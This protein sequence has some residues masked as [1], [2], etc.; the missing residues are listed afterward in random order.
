[1]GL[2]SV[3]VAQQDVEK[4][5]QDGVVVLNNVVSQQTLDDLAQALDDNMKSPG[6][7]ANE[8]ADGS[9]QGRFFDDYVNWARFAA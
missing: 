9:Q 1:M 5:Q 8:Y 3:L 7:W 4:F 6:P 2:P